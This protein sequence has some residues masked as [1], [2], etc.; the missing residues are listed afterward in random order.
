MDKQTVTLSNHSSSWASCF[1]EVVSEIY[2]SVSQNNIE[3]HHIGSTSI[4]G[5]VAKPIIDILGTVEDISEA[6]SY[7]TQFESLGFEYKGEYG[8]DGRRFCIL[9]DE[10]QNL[11]FIHL[12]IFQQDHHEVQRHL[13]FRDYLRKYPEVAQRYNQLKLDV[14]EK[15]AK[16][17]ERYTN[18]KADLISE[19]LEEAGGDLRV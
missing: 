10:S 15:Y 19:I 12:H 3:L 4:P 16:D 13:I 5:I 1:D 11:G 14:V 8:I 6:D 9:Y 2:K 17:R 18:S 7:R